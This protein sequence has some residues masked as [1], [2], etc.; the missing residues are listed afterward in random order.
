[1]LY[2]N[3]ILCYNI[4]MSEIVSKDKEGSG[5]MLDGEEIALTPR[6]GRPLKA[7]HHNPEWFPQ[8]TKVDACTFYCVYGDFD[9]VSELTKVPVPML[10]SWH[11]E[12]WWVEIQ[13][14]VYVEQNEN[15]SARINEVLDKS[16]VEIKDRLEHGDMFFDR[17]AGEFRR[18][19]VDTKTLAILF[20]NLTTKRQLVRGEPTAISAKVGVE[21]RLAQ[22]ADSFEKFAKSRLIENGTVI[23]ESLNDI[24]ESSYVE[25]GFKQEDNIIQHQDGNES[26]ETTET[27]S[28]NSTLQSGQIQK[29]EEV[30]EHRINTETITGQT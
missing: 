18:K 27:S 17:K 23:Q 16:L 13:K 2:I 19:P 6:R 29:E 12:P 24:K 1:M 28:S 26:R 10:R 3:F 4:C 21:D 9:K 11:Q 20:D 14:K 15:L 30:N 22:L 25:E 8:Q 7:K 5:Y